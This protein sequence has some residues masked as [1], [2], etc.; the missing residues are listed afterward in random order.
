[1]VLDQIHI[2]KKVKEKRG[3]RRKE[4]EGNKEGREEENEFL[5]LLC[6]SMCLWVF[7]NRE[8]SWT[9]RSW[10]EN[11][12]YP[13]REPWVSRKERKNF[14]RGIIFTYTTHFC[15]FLEFFCSYYYVLH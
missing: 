2:W 9:Q 3:E 14:Y 1:M 12:N 8:K 4:K 15:N 6:I 5:C 13:R 11:Y 10:A 7:V